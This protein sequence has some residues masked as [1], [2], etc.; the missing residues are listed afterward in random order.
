MRENFFKNK[1]TQSGFSLIEAVIAI[2]IITVILVSMVAV[3]QTMVIFEKK[4]LKTRQATLLADQAIEVTKSLRDDDWANIENLDIGEKY[5]LHFDD[6]DWA[7]NLTPSMVNGF[8]QTVTAQTAY[9]DG[10]GKIAESGTADEST[11][12][13][14]AEVSWPHVGETATVTSKTYLTDLFS[15]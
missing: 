14:V 11:R 9:R 6:V 2:A 3:F 12:L 15:E 5:Y 10:S 7:L 4:T 13:I 8:T 1:S